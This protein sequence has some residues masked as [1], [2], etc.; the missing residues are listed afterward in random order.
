MDLKEI[1]NYLKVKNIN[2]LWHFTDLSNLDSIK[3]YGL[4]SL[5][6]INKY[7]IKVSRFGAEELSHSLDYSRGLDKFVHLSF[8]KDHPM[9]YVAKS[10]GSIINPIW[11]KINISVLFQK[12]N[13]LC[14]G[15]ANATN[16]ILFGI[17][18]INRIDFDNMN[19]SDFEIAKNAR[20]AEILIYNQVPANLIEGVYF[21]K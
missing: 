15:V 17:D 12:E 11:L 9:Y 5:H 21:G 8:I 18:E 3:K 7:N 2:Y 14:N 1:N 13:L 20:K 19:N 6:N 16:S 10:R 4:Q